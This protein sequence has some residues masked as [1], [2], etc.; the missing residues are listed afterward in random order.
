M[1][2][3]PADLAAEH[4]DT[5]VKIDAYIAENNVPGAIQSTAEPF[6]L[7]YY[8]KV[9][10]TGVSLEIEDPKF[11]QAIRSLRIDIDDRV[12]DK[13]K[14]KKRNQEM[15]G[16]DLPQPLL[17]GTPPKVLLQRYSSTRGRISPYLK[18]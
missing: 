4:Q 11:K 6:D 14:L 7:G 8:G 5:I 3:I 12:T 16:D 15:F 17:E 2:I 1:T 18:N 10:T 9:S 13:E